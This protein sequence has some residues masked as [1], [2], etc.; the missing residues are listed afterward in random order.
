[1]RAQKLRFNGAFV[2]DEAFNM[3]KAHFNRKKEGALREK[4]CLFRSFPRVIL[5]NR[6]FVTCF[7]SEMFGPFNMQK[8]QVPGAANPMMSS[9]TKMVDMLKNNM[10]FMIP[11]VVVGGFISYFFA[12]FVL[13]KV[14]FPLTNRFKAMLQRGIDLTYVP[15]RTRVRL[16]FTRRLNFRCRWCETEPWTCPT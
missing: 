7:A 12:G 2:S 14:P 11:N 5:R 16:F 1:M 15:A 8:M 10:T 4:V 3:R 6:R 9:P 13:A